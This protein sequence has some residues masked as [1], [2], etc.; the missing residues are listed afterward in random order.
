MLNEDSRSSQAAYT[1]PLCCLRNIVDKSAYEEEEEE[2][3]EE[4]EETDAAL[5]S[6]DEVGR[7]I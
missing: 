4:V 5:L 6:A 3:E 1:I 2:E 7:G